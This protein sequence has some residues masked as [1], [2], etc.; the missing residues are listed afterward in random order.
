MQRRFLRGRLA[1]GNWR[2]Q[3]LVVFTLCL[4]VFF[5]GVLGFS[6]TG[7]S[8]TG[9]HAITVTTSAVPAVGAVV[10]NNGNAI[11]LT[12]N[13]TT[14]IAVGYTVADAT[15][16]GH[17]FYQ[18]N[19]TTT[20]YRSGVTGGSSCAASPLNCYI[21]VSPSTHNCSGPASTSTNAN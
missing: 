2:L 16:C 3:R 18:G 14:T 13:T 5:A 19:V 17:V 4:G 7:R 20:L 6:T 8:Q 10:L 12:A 21:S 9:D 1:I 11:T 15:S